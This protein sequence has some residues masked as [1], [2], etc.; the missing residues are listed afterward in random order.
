MAGELLLLV[1]LALAL[2][3]LMAPRP[4][5]ASPAA[6]EAPAELQRL[7]ALK[8]GDAADA[9]PGPPRDR[10]QRE[11]AFSASVQAGARWRYARILEERV[12]PNE[13]KLDRLFDFKALMIRK[14]DVW[15]LP[16]VATGAGRAV[17]LEEGSLKASGQEKSYRL[18]EK[19]KMALGPPDWREY[20]AAGLPQPEDIHPSILP[21]GLREARLWRER[22]DK[23][24]KTGAEEAEDLFRRRAALL[25]RDYAGMLL[26][27]ELSGERLV[28]GPEVKVTGKARSARDE[29]LV[30]MLTEY[31]LESRGTFLTEDPAAAGRAGRQGG[32]GKRPG[33]PGRGE[34]AAASAAAAGSA[35]ARAGRG[36][37][38]SQA[39]PAGPE[40]RG[41][42][43]GQ[44]A[45]KASE[46]GGENR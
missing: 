27:R 36:T 21:S 4:S 32:Q 2:L 19:A 12:A 9:R 45:R 44:P 38:E 18:V 5:L 40:A 20:L 8:G 30:Y 29:E 37:A 6:E 7:R 34:A 23:G 35:A 26:F 15:V 22:V 14:G 17:R 24:W 16:P 33:R 3:M 46:A 1:I 10:A 31:G 11:A 42:M 25:A 39:G 43:P 28:S 41:G 13:A